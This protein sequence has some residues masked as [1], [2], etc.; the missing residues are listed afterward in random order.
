MSYGGLAA[1]LKYDLKHVDRYQYGRFLPDLALVPPFEKIGDWYPFRLVVKS[2]RMTTFVDGRK[3]HEASLPRECDPWLAFFAQGHLAGSARKITISGQPS[4]PERLDLSA[5]PDLTGWLAD[6][7]GDSVGVNDADWDKRGDEIIGHLQGDSSRKKL[8]SVLR[9][10]HPLL[11]DGEIGYDFYYE[12]GETMVHPAL[13]R[14][15][16][17]LEPDGVKIHWLTDAQ[18]ERNG[19]K[20]DNACSEADTTRG[21]SSLPLKPKDWNR[22]VLSLAGDRVTLRLNQTE[23]A[24][25]RLEPANQ[26]IFGLFHYA[27]ETEVRVRNVSYA[28]QWPR[29]L[30]ESLREERNRKGL[31]TSSKSNCMHSINPA[32]GACRPGASVLRRVSS[33]L[34]QAGAGLTAEQPAD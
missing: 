7:Y 23:I 12:P 18:F 11:E 22:L 17:L 8:E 2:G 26:R 32:S 9:Y 33:G 3:I 31:K 14:L 16:F 24:V 30:P 29:K 13:G 25:R 28:G 34:Y 6:D 5:L 21:P 19:L 20:A 10:N 4:I 1:A 27:D 15:A